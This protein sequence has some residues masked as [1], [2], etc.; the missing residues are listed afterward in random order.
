MGRWPELREPAEMA[1]IYN[2][3]GVRKTSHMTGLCNH[4]PHVKI[5]LTLYLRTNLHLNKAENSCFQQV[6]G[7]KD[8][9]GCDNR[10]QRWNQPS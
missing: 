8:S 10:D 1:A 9:T 4:C 5:H 6:F 3:N 7:E 2:D